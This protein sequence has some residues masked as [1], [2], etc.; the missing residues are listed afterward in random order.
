MGERPDPMKSFRI[1]FIVPGDAPP[2]TIWLDAYKAVWAKGDDRM[3]GGAEVVSVSA[4]EPYRLREAG[5][6]NKEAQAVMRAVKL[7]ID[8]PEDGWGDE[9]SKEFQRLKSAYEIW[10]QTKWREGS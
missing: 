4:P 6:M 1:E 7:Y 8:A 2:P 9:T 10:E 5:P 3:I